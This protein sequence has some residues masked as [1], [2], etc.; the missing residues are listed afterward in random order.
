MADRIY[1]PWVPSF[2]PSLA[3]LADVPDALEPVRH[4]VAFGESAENDLREVEIVSELSPDH[5]IKLADS[6]PNTWSMLVVSDP[7]RAVLEKTSVKIEFYSIRIRDLKG[8]LVKKPYFLANP[9][10]TVDCMDRAQSD[11]DESKIARWQ[12]RRFRRLVLDVGKIPNDRTIF[13]LES[14]RQLILVRKDLAYEIYRVHDFR[15]MIFQSL[16][17][18]GEEFR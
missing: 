12:V 7:L 14:Q 2:E 8:R 13:R 17:S 9:I 4:K 6:V 18:F 16:E 15:G 11:Y 1:A 10:G 5:G 3:W